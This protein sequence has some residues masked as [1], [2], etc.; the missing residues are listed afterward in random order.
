ME[1]RESN[2]WIQAIGG[3]WSERLL[4]E[5]GYGYEEATKH[6]RPPHL[7]ETMVENNIR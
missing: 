2:N 5:I 7:S 6:R 1:L 3:P 4:I